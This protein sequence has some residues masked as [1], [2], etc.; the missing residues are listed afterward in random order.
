MSTKIYYA[1]RTPISRLAEFGRLFDDYGFEVTVSFVKK[2]MATVAYDKCN[3]IWEKYKNNLTWEEFQTHREN[4][5]RYSIIMKLCYEALD[6]MQIEFFDIDFGFNAFLSSAKAYIIP[7]GTRKV[8]GSF[9]PPD[10]VEEYGYWNNT[11]QPLDLTRRQW[12]ARGD[13]WDE[14]ALDDWQKNRFMH[15]SVDL[16]ENI[17]VERINQGIFD[18]EDMLRALIVS[19]DIRLNMLHGAEMDV[20]PHILAPLNDREKNV[21]I[22]S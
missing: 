7:Y 16:K 21:T 22:S 10:W 13:K 3:E 8:V 14:V 5:L 15:A 6:S 4:M 2:M 18:E 9:T 20:D 12:K 1:W 11:D 19:S 17:G